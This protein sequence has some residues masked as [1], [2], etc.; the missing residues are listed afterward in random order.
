MKGH[1]LIGTHLITWE[2]QDHPPPRSRLIAWLWLHYD[3]A[4]FLINVVIWP[5][6]DTTYALHLWLEWTDFPVGFVWS[7]DQTPRRPGPLPGCARLQCLR[8]R[9]DRHQ[10]NPGG[11]SGPGSRGACGPSASPS[12]ILVISCQGPCKYSL[13]SSSISVAV[14]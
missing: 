4:T 5:S 14:V 3:R 11:S 13:Q 7:H 9:G 6:A 12:V 1:F 2:C 10:Q 8:R